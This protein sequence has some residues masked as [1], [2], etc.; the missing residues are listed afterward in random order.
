M[1][2][3]RHARALDLAPRPG[4]TDA[5]VVERAAINTALFTFSGRSS[6]DCCP[7]PQTTAWVGTNTDTWVYKD[8]DTRSKSQE[9]RHHR[10]ERILRRSRLHHFGKQVAASSSSRVRGTH[11]PSRAHT[12]LFALDSGDRSVTQAWQETSAA[13]RDHTTQ[14]VTDA[15][16]SFSPFQLKSKGLSHTSG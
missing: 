6:E 2:A 5:G 15:S 13:S 1:W 14:G 8:Q 11:T 9:D 3:A 4:Q 7:S 10:F 12:T 16:C